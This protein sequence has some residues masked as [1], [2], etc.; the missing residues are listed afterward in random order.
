MTDGGMVF[1]VGIADRMLTA[2]SSRIGRHVPRVDR[3]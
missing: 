2:Q 3:A 1:D